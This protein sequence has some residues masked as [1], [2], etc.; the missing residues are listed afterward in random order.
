MNGAVQ[1][2][3]GFARTSRALNAGDLGGAGDGMSFDLAP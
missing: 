3:N 2:H 1:G